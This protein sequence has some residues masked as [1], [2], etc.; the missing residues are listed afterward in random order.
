MAG[1]TNQNDPC[2]CPMSLRDV[3]QHSV[4]CEVTRAAELKAAA[5]RFAQ[6][7][8]ADRRAAHEVARG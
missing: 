5:E 6:R 3:G 2:T 8:N 1:N 7:W 4:A